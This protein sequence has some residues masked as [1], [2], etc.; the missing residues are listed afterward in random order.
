MLPA[1]AAVAAAGGLIG[2]TR[3][4]GELEA[5]LDDA[6]A[7]RGSLVLVV[8]APG[9]GK[10]RLADAFAGVAAARGAAVVWGRAWEAGGAPAYWPWI[11]GLRTL[12]GG[13]TL[14]AA[15]LASDDA[16]RTRFE[17]HD[18]IATGLARLARER[19]LV[20]VLDDVHV[21]DPGTLAL[22]HFVARSLRGARVVVVA[23]QRDVGARPDPDAAEALGK[24]AREAR[25]VAL[26][27][28]GRGEVT[29]WLADQAPGVDAQAI[30][31]ASEGNPLFV[32]EMVRLARDRGAERALA[33]G[34]LPDGVRDV[35][36]ARLDVL[37]PEARAFWRA[38]AV[39]GRAV[40][41][42][43][44]LTLAAV[45]PSSARALI[46]EAVRAEL[47]RG[48]GELTFAFTH[49][50]LREVLYAEL[51]PARRHELH[52]LVARTLI[53]RAEEDPTATLIEPLHHLVAAGPLVS[54]DEL[55]ALG[56]RAAERATARLAFEDAVAALERVVSL[57]PHERAADRCD[58]L[59][60]LAAALVG[61]ARA[62]RACETAIAAAAV[63]RA[64]GDVERL[65]RA[66]L[67]YGSIFRFAV[68]DPALVGLLEEALAGL[69]PGESP[70]RARLLARLAAALQPADD[71]ERPLGIARDAIAMADRVADDATRLGVLTAATSAMAYF[72]APE[73]RRPFD[74]ELIALGERLGDRVAVVRGHLRLAWDLL[75][76][77]D[78]AG[79]DAEIAAHDRLIA[80]T[81]LPELV[82]R[83]PLLRA[84]RA[85]MRGDFA[86]AE[87]LAD[88]A[89][90]LPTRVDDPNAPFSLAM[91]RLGRL[92]ASGRV[93][94]LARHITPAIEQVHRVT[95]S[96]YA[97]CLRAGM[98]ARCGRA[99]EARADLA[100]IVSRPQY[101][102]MRPMLAWAAEAAVALGDRKTGA[103]L[104]DAL[105]P[106]A[107]RLH[108]WGAIAMVCETPLS[109][110]VAR[111]HALLGDRA[112]ASRAFD[113]ALRRTEALDA[114]PLLAWI[115]RDRAAE[116]APAATSTTSRPT[117]PAAAAP[118]VTLA[119]DGDGWAI[120][121]AGGTFRLK[122]SRGLQILAL[123]VDTPGREHHVVELVAPPGQAAP[124]EDAGDALDPQAI[125][126]YRARLEDLRDAEQEAETNGDPTRA[127]RAR[128][129]L[130]AIADELARGVGLGGRARKTASTA[131]RARI[132]VRQRLQDAITRIAAHDVTLG[133]HLRQAIRTGTFCRYDP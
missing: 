132:N 114:P 101:L 129:E 112:A 130:D 56:R 19:P 121:H 23:T 68:V 119:R 111:L 115:E 106:L 30:Y 29:S 21:A 40:R 88:E 102:R 69:P 22:A 103:L 31:D 1:V 2:R 27:P 105:A 97:Y 10:T 18:A 109:H 123:L 76:T 52:A 37:S 100:W 75:E 62:T 24:I 128:A 61:A 49:I 43:L 94:E 26:A 35:I 117:P 59:L 39:L 20:V 46:D 78:T 54:A 63:A 118:T 16:P 4:L 82:W 41:P 81:P 7:G 122:D 95:D 44:A 47:V 108:G 125:A 67:A 131:E 77:G 51:E 90:A 87:R 126:A 84:M 120:T 60:D 11:E 104:L 25:Y 13:D 93:E 32:V 124:L 66:A 12:D 42:T 80:R 36:R 38:A 64:T 83:A 3:E 73:V 48:D 72:E 71:P 55:I 65:A 50:L 91:Q 45:T 58:L 34:R 99:A 17:R 133:K 92:W 53:A 15:L 98:F 116:L 28:L 5:A 79:A 33:A 86:A 8:G 127:A 113:D 74:L 96:I 6:T 110:P 9:I 70:L 89:T 85:I 14:A 107:P 57:V